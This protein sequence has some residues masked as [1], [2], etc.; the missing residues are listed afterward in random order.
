MGKRERCRTKAK[1]SWFSQLPPWQRLLIK[2]LV[3]L[4]LVGIIVGIAV[5]ISIRVDGGVYKGN[6]QTSDIGE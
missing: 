2:I 1:V 4:V 3:G 5:G 6:N